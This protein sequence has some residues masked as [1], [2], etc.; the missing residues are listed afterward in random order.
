MKSW[1][2]FGTCYRSNEDLLVKSGCI[3]VVGPLRDK[4]DR[5][6]PVALRRNMGL[7]SPSCGIADMWTS[8]SRSE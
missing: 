4:Y 3:S 1:N 7:S 5:F 6:V 8:R 2:D